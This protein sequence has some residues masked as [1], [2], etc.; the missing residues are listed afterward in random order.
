MTTRFSFRALTSVTIAISFVV[1]VLSGIILFLAP[2]GRI[3]NWTDWTILGLTK[4]DWGAL[5]IV[6]TTLFLVASSFHIYFNWRPLLTYFR[7]RAAKGFQMR[8]EWLVALAFC[9]VVY[10]GLRADLPPV[11]SLL[12]LNENLKSSWDQP[13]NQ[14]PIPH[15][16]L[17]TLAELA[18]QAGVELDEAKARLEAKDLKEV[19]DSVVV[20]DLA[21]QNR[22]SAQ[23]VYDFIL[24]PGSPGSREG[25]PRGEGNRGR[26]QG[27]GG[28]GGMGWLTLEQ[29]CAQEN[30]P[31][32]QALQ[33]LTGEGY[34][35][36]AEWTLRETA[37][38]NGFDRPY[39]LL[40]LLRQQEKTPQ[41]DQ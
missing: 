35:A 29:F 41:L 13:A 24:P 18:K 39:A 30:I 4:H 21:A 26:G 9:A 3:A 16:E 40:Q 12:A 14:A 22:I 25:E 19:S 15:A 20:E 37:Q 2:P 32:E 28:G 1:V 31:I 36:N 34:E 10:G 11:S 6:F 17:L 8:W 23:D 33:K 5:H 27:G 7:S 38:N